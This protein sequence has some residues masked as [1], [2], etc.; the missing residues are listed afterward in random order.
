MLNIEYLQKLTRS[1]NDIFTGYLGASAANKNLDPTK[2]DWSSPKTYAGFFDGF[3]LA[4]NVAGG[5]TEAGKI[6]QTFSNTFIKQAFVP[7]VFTGAI[8]FGFVKAA[9]ANND[10]YAFWEWNWDSE[11]MAV[12]FGEMMDGF[13]TVVSVSATI[14]GIRTVNV[15]GSAAKDFGGSFKEKLGKTLND[16]NNKISQANMMKLLAKVPKS[17]REKVT[18]VF[19]ALQKASN[20]KN[21]DDMFDLNNYKLN[22]R[23]TYEGLINGYMEGKALAS[24]SFEI[25]KSMVKFSKQQ[26]VSESLREL[27]RSK[28]SV[29]WKITLALDPEFIKY[30]VR[31]EIHA[32]VAPHDDDKSHTDRGNKSRVPEVKSEIQHSNTFGYIVPFALAS[33][34]TTGIPY[35]N[36]FNN[37]SFNMLEIGDK[38]L[39]Q[40]DT[41][42]NLTLLNLLVETFFNS[43][44][45]S[46]KCSK[47]YSKTNVENQLI[48]SEI[49]NDFIEKFMQNAETCLF[50]DFIINALVESIDLKLLN[51]EVEKAIRVKNY[52]KVVRLMEQKVLTDN[53]KFLIKH[54][55]KDKVESLRSNMEAELKRLLEK[56]DKYDDTS[57][58]KN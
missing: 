47:A 49:V 36:S 14:G 29:K 31:P 41:V 12:T 25:N 54:S 48:T 30:F 17:F 53:L 50:T 5:L 44:K 7:A 13:S 35:E 22:E 21:L 2:W 42:G 40:T 20:A 58:K 34:S 27:N 55:S 23:S 28:R 33:P 32:V 3:T 8:G 51:R 11:G 24:E 52:P 56:L 10:N 46:K 1:C 4:F 39:Q 37:S 18:G 45:K 19:K 57:C 16:I 26:K 9:S 43:K 38:W 15:K 6:A